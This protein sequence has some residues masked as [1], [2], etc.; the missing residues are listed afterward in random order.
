MRQW[1]G[2]NSLSEQELYGRELEKAK[3]MNMI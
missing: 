1:M 2:L 3:E